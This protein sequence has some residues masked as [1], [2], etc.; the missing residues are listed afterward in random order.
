MR[1][2]LGFLAEGFIHGQSCTLNVMPGSSKETSSYREIIC[3]PAESWL[4]APM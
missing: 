3:S 4:S 1:I 2:A